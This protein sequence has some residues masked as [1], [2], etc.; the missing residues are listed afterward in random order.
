MINKNYKK[1]KIG[2]LG[3][4]YVGLPLA[5]CLSKKFKVVGFDKNRKRILQLRKN[6]DYTNEIKKK[7]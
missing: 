5:D 1:I 7:I 2:I 3:L 6:F 4:G